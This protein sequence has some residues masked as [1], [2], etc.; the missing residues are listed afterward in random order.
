[1]KNRIKMHMF[2]QIFVEKWGIE[3]GEL[4]KRLIFFSSIS[5]KSSAALPLLIQLKLLFPFYPK[6]TSGLDALYCSFN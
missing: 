6:E 4:G 5:E 2:L 1:M 3:T